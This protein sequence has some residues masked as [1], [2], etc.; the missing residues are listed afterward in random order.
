MKKQQFNR[1]KAVEIA[2]DVLEQLR[3]EK[4]VAS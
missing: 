2:R 4:F 3:V 1:K